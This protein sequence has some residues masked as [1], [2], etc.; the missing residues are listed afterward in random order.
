VPRSTVGLTGLEVTHLAPATV[1]ATERGSGWG[2]GS[3]KET[4]SWGSA[5]ATEMGT[6]SG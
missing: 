5:T 3:A 4:G 6:G 2:S 1:T